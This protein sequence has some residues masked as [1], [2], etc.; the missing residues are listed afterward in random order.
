MT[1]SIKKTTLRDITIEFL[2]P[3]DKEETLKAAR[4]KNHIR[5]RVKNKDEKR[6]LVKN[7]PS[8]KTVE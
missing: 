3:H 4:E 5:Y 6:F 1:R 2:K 7:K 8:K